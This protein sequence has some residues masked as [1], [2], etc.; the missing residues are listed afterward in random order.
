MQIIIEGQEVRFNRP[1]ATIT[2]KPKHLG[3]A[4]QEIKSGVTGTVVGSWY[5]PGGGGMW[6]KRD[7]DGKI[8]QSATGFK[9]IQTYR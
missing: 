2:R 1:E 7:F 3:Q 4:I 8:V 5:H 6:I 9:V